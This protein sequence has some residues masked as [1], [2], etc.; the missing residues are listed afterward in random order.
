MFHSHGFKFEIMGMILF[1]HNQMSIRRN[2][3]FIYMAQN[4]T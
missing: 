2:I 3:C 1:L 4:A